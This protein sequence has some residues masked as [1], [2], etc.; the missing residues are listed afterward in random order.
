MEQWLKT[1]LSQCL[2]FEVP[3]EMIGYILSIKS[4]NELDEYFKTLLD[5]KNN[6][7]VLFLN[8]LKSRM[9]AKKSPQSNDGEGKGK[10]FQAKNQKQRQIE[11]LKIPEPQSKE[12]H[13]TGAKKKTKFVNLYGQDGEIKDSIM[14]KGRHLCDCQASKHKLVNNC[15]KCGRI[16]CEQEGSG[17]CLF[18]GNLVCTD[19]EQ[20]LIDSSSKKG[21]NLKRTLMEQKRPLGWEEAVATRN[22]L[23]EYDRNSEKRTTVIDDESDYFKANSVWLSDSER[24]KLEKAEIELRERKH[25]SRLNKKITIDFSGRQV[26]EEPQLT[27]DIEDEILQS[28]A[29]SVENHSFYELSDDVHP[30]LNCPPPVF[31]D[32]VVEP[33]FKKPSK[34]QE[35]A[36]K[37]Q[38]KEFLEMSDLKACISMHQPWASLLVAGI[39][40]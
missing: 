2:C 15:M 22:R 27:I 20:K 3:D 37:V 17:P 29:Q 14:L 6:D 4:N 19:E 13:P 1:R 34:Y 30:G 24:K 9:K 10:K 16:I 38:D 26:I 31:D 23:L 25:A 12:Q 32:S 35:K 36:S 39:K 33:T 7:N 28:I 8:E 11:E 5:L 18:C 40:R 21:D